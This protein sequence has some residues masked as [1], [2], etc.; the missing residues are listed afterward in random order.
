MSLSD[1]TPAP[2]PSNT[3]VLVSSNIEIIS[4]FPANFHTQKQRAGYLEIP[5]LLFRYGLD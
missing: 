5:G 3:H 1:T 4:P 2:Y